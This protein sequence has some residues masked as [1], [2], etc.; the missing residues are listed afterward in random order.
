[1]A[2]A[3]E[4]IRRALVTLGTQAL[5]TV[6]DTPM[7]ANCPPLDSKGTHIHMRRSRRELDPDGS[8]PVA[9]EEKPE[10]P[11]EDVVGVCTAAIGHSRVFC[12]M[13]CLVC[14]ALDS[15]PEHRTDAEAWAMA[16]WEEYK[17]SLV[18]WEKGDGDE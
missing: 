6:R 10:P 5:E 2:V 18:E 9:L 14:D 1:M 15:D 7:E 13:G 12:G 8:G 3:G 11:G 17:N 4:H 16:A